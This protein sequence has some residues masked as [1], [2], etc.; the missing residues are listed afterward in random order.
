MN[1]HR[2]PPTCNLSADGSGGQVRPALALVL[3]SIGVALLLLP[4][5]YG[6]ANSRQTA[7]PEAREARERADDEPIAY[8]GHG[9]FFDPKGDQ[10]TPT[11]EWVA[12]T[13]NW[14]RKRL[15]A[16]LDSNRQAELAAFERRLTEDLAP[17]GQAGLVVQQRLL[18]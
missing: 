18:D 7:E 16:G 14:Y 5:A 10:I 6:S 15:L 1:E 11:L 17:E 13:Q 12:E 9:G 3:L 8:V 2:L 4:L